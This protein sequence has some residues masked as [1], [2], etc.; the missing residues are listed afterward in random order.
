MILTER[1]L[2]KI[3]NGDLD[4]L[5]SFSKNYI[6][7]LVKDIVESPLRWK[8]LSESFDALF[9]KNQKIAFLI[10]F[11]LPEYANYWRRHLELDYSEVDY[12]G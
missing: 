6:D 2:W 5:D 11:D 3:L 12:E 8:I 10:S 9:K 4:F 1:I 7:D